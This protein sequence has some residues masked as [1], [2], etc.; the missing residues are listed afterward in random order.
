MHKIRNTQQLPL[1]LLRQKKN[2]QWNPKILLFHDFKIKPIK[3]V[4]WP[5]TNIKYVVFLFSM[6]FVFSVIFN[7]WFW[8]L[9]SE[10]VSSITQNIY[11]FLWNKRPFLGPPNLSS[12]KNFKKIYWTNNNFCLNTNNSWLQQGL[13]KFSKFF[14]FV[15]MPAK[16][17]LISQSLRSI[18]MTISFRAM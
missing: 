15:C 9:P 17:K 1:L 5:D 6:G 10:M 14:N 4:F 12:I 8:L 3:C 2:M 7:R 11:K 18:Y 16:W 13:K